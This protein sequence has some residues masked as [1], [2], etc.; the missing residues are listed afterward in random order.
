MRSRRSGNLSRDYSADAERLFREFA[1]RHDLTIEKIDEPN[2][3][4]LMRVPQ[5]KGLSFE[6]TLC[7]QNCDELNIGVAEFWSTFFPFEKVK[8]RVEA[9]LDGL[10]LGE[11]SVLTT[12]RS[13]RY[14][15]GKLQ[16]KAD[17]GWETITIHVAGLRVPFL[18]TTTQRIANEARSS[19]IV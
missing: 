12:W 18:R 2:V 11:C 13:G 17:A 4:L 6:I 7:C 19:G 14:V 3:E 8:Q 1:A 15:G 16:R 5:Q 10:V 9:A